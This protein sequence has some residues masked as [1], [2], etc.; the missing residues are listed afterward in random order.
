MSVNPDATPRS[1]HGEVTVET[2][3]MSRVLYEEV[4]FFSQPMRC[5]TFHMCVYT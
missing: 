1:E 2:G 4:N 3:V 5:C